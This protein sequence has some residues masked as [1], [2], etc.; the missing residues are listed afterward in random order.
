MSCGHTW[1]ACSINSSVIRPPGTPR[2]RDE[3]NEFLYWAPSKTQ[4]D[5]IIYVLD[6]MFW[7]VVG[8]TVIYKMLKIMAIYPHLKGVIGTWVKINVQE[9]ARFSSQ[10]VVATGTAVTSLTHTSAC[11]YTLLPASQQTGIRQNIL[12]SN[13][14]VN[15]VVGQFKLVVYYQIVTF[16][17]KASPKYLADPRVEDPSSDNA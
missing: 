15:D 9:N 14:T 2:L 3:Y 17:C 5:I 4:Y 7:Y 13:I 11:A 10:L 6:I 16:C 8:T 1:V 12:L